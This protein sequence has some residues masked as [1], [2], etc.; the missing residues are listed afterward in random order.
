MT[1]AEKIAAAKAR[2]DAAP[3]PNVRGER[4]P[5]RLV[6]CAH[7]GARVPG[8]PCGSPLLAC[9]LHGDVTA[10]FRE[11]S[12]AARTCAACPDY[13]VAPN[14]PGPTVL[15]RYDETNLF[16]GLPGRRFNPGLIEWGDGYVFCWRD[17][18][19]GS[20]LWACRMD[21]AFRP[22]PGARAVRL[23][24]NHPDANYGREDPQLFVHD[25]RLHVALVG[26]V[27]AGRRVSRTA[28][29]YARLSDALA[30]EA[31]YAPRAPGVPVS[32]WQKNWQWFSHGGSLY[33]VY[34]V[35]PHRVLRVDGERAEWVW[36][37]PV[38]AP[39]VGG[40]IRGGATPY[41]VGHEFY[42][43]FHDK[44]QRN[45]LF[46][47]VGCYTFSADPPFRPLRM[48]SVPLI[49]SNPATN[50][51]NYC[52][53]VFPRGAVRDDDSWVL[54]CGVHDRF[55]ELYRLRFGDV[56][57]ALRPVV[58]ATFSCRPNTVDH[59]VLDSVLVQNEYRLPPRLAPD[60]LVVD[61]G[62]HVGAFAA[63]AWAR[64]ARNVH[65]YEASRVNFEALANN[66]ARMPGVT[67]HHKAVWGATGDVV[68]CGLDEI[69]KGDPSSGVWYKVWAGPVA[70]G[71]E[72][73][74]TISLDDIV[75]GRRV[76]VLKLDCEGSEFPILF[77]C[78]CLHLIDRIAMEVH[79]AAGSMVDL[80]TGAGFAVDLRPAPDHPDR[81][82][83]L[84]AE[85]T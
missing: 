50:P 79:G 47:R 75:A 78:N 51:G 70:G 60:G 39:W 57:A 24:I 42:C 44:V 5:L 17:G 83:L 29:L 73:V 63:A 9:K 8:Q 58:P 81:L 62:A 37:E 7:L 72:P 18:W 68:S 33:A 77:G 69:A 12:G 2:A 35:T 22:A 3:P 23:D 43:F 4:V 25:G 36:S 38:N 84:F 31:V 66:V 55:T 26:V 45:K 82:A 32:Q 28:V 59:Q 14:V 15:A 65:C 19:K 48:T 54:S 40:E 13:S 64:G 67:A 71:A 85:R 52:D 56:E 16:A 61:I 6:P 41:R 21:R 74:A 20:N 76:A 27:G 1:R 34:S 53:C 46:Y 10:R 49:E 11:C 30:V 80:L